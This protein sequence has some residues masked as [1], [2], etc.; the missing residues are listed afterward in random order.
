MKKR[1]VVI[2]DLH[3]GHEYGLTP[4][5]WMK[6]NRSRI[7]H[8]KKCGQF[9]RALW[10][11]YIKA[12]DSL[13]PID[14]LYLNGDAVEGRGEK[15]NQIELISTDPNV[16]A[17]M[18]EQCILQAEAKSIRMTF[19]TRYHVLN[20]VQ[21]EATLLNLLLRRKLNAKIDGHGFHEV[22]GRNFDLKHKLNGSGIPHGR[23]TNLA[24]ENLWNQIWASEGRQPRGEYFIRSHVHFFAFCGGERWTAM[25]SPALTYN[26]I[27]GIRECSGIVDVGLLVFD[28]SENGDTA[29][30]PVMAKFR[31]L[32][33]R[34]E[35]L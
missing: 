18:A 7:R 24:K 34:A 21:V 4:P 20:G 1:M 8:E 17:E 2:S 10:K 35:S 32:K 16:Q 28:V 19:G 33:V 25:A 14:I 9:E 30:H 22:N 13:K 3:C 12:L 26:S 5:D 23:F 11:F 15:T 6:S 27:Y 29:W 31:E